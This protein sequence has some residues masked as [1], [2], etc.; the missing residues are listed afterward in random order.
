[1]AIS[2]NGHISSYSNGAII[3]FIS[4][5]S[6]GNKN[7]NYVLDLKWDGRVITKADCDALVN[8]EWSKSR[9]VLMTQFVTNI[10]NR[11]TLS[12]DYCSVIQPKYSYL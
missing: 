6:A 1:V 3:I 12:T 4:R 9:G 2:E 10:V 5:K 7:G 8:N 11:L